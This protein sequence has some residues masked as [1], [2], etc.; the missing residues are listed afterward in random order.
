MTTAVAHAIPGLI[1]A[2]YG[3]RILLSHDVCWKIFLKAYGGIGFTFIQEQF[4]PYLR[5]IGVTDAQI[6]AM[7]IGN[8]ARAFTFV[9]PRA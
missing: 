1:E 6:D 3:D 2:G 7:M 9:A 4:L 5:T 8:P